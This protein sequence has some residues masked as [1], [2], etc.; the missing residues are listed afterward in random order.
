MN[1]T[2]LNPASLRKDGE[3]AEGAA[4]AAGP[5]GG[6]EVPPRE[7]GAGWGHLAGAWEPDD[8][9]GLS[10]ARKP[11]NPE[12]GGQLGTAARDGCPPG[13]HLGGRGRGLGSG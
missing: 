4:G 12:W 13:S 6:E 3:A 7:G 9:T 8:F 5:L 2:Q 1:S 11:P 10:K